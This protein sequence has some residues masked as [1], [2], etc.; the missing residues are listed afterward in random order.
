MRLFL[1]NIST[2]SNVI[3]NSSYNNMY[4]VRGYTCTTNIKKNMYDFLYPYL[5]WILF[6][7]YLLCGKRHNA[8]GQNDIIFYLVNY[9]FCRN[10]I[11]GNSWTQT[12]RCNMHGN[13]FLENLDN[14]SYLKHVTK[15][16]D[17]YSPIIFPLFLEIFLESRNKRFNW[18]GHVSSNTQ[19]IQELRNW[20]HVKILLLWTEENFWNRFISQF[21]INY[22][23]KWRN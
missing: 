10:F 17:W 22:Q 6:T 19:G 3:Q 14:H 18:K 20:F 15:S 5:F 11:C 9:H 4:I 2:S 1:W 7:L 13:F 8:V 23:K 21:W 16:T 12:Y